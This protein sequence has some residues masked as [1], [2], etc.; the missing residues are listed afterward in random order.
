M[1][2][3]GMTLKERVLRLEASFWILAAVVALV[4]VANT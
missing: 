4:A 2:H 1:M 3:K